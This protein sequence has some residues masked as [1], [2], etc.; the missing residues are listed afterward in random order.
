MRVLQILISYTRGWVPRWTLRA[1]CYALRSQ[2]GGGNP[3][4]TLTMGVFRNIH[5]GAVVSRAPY[6]K[7]YEIPPDYIIVVS[8]VVLSPFILLGFKDSADYTECG[9]GGEGSDSWGIKTHP[10]YQRK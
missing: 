7:Y 2:C 4:F 10:S 8:W 1:T 9:D 6:F 5:L 3:K